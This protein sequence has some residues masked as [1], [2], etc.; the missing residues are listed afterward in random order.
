M[1]LF[2]EVFV[3][4]FSVTLLFLGTGLFLFMLFK[5]ATYITNLEN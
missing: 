4:L 1:N 3:G 2:E 5:A